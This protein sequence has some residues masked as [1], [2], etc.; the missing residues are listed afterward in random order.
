MGHF[1][2]LACEAD[3]EVQPHLSIRDLHVNLWA[4]KGLGFGR[5]L[6]HFDIGIEIKNQGPRD[7]QC[8][9]L[10]LPFVVEKGRWGS[11]SGEY[12][13]DLF[14]T[15]VDPATA[16]LIFG[17]PVKISSYEDRRAVIEFENREVTAVGISAIN[18][19]P[20]NED[21]KNFSHFRVPF[22]EPLAPE[23]SAYIRMR[24]RVFSGSPIWKWSRTDAGARMDFRIGDTRQAPQS[25][26]SRPEILKRSIEIEKAY[27]FAMFPDN[28]HP[29]NVSPQPKYIRTLE[30][31]AWSPYLRSTA[32]PW[33]AKNLIVYGW[34]SPKKEKGEGSN[35]SP[36]PIDSNNP[37]RIFMAVNR[38]AAKPQWY[39]VALAALGAYLA[40]LITQVDYSV[41]PWLDK[42]DKLPEWI[43]KWLP[44]IGIGSILAFWNFIQKIRPYFADRLKSPRLL[45]RRLERWAIRHLTFKNSSF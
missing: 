25:L 6:F 28:M 2:V 19:S 5:R 23:S 40:Y 42:F 8:I 10:L 18:T 13:L 29:E 44:L 31:S 37:F 3:Q 45:A 17:A 26:T 32:H 33:Q 11:A 38:S 30:S 41:F 16:S 12:A 15:V 43:E 9:E 27:V 7:I 35:K 39:I 14:D 20:V 24:W 4:I 36:I 34:Q 22:S 1:A 21:E